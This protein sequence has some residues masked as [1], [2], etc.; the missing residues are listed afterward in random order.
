MTSNRRTSDQIINVPE[1]IRVLEIVSNAKG[2]K[3]VKTF[4]M[5]NTTDTPYEVYWECVKDTSNNSIKC[6]TP[7]SFISS[8]KRFFCT[9]EFTP[10]S[11]QTV[12][13]LWSFSI[14]AYDLKAEI[15]IVGRVF[16]SAKN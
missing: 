16:N 13:S 1:N 5:I 10:K 9:F 2:N 15:L 7:Q 8:G 3:S 6:T 4:E 14:P 12:E 11:H